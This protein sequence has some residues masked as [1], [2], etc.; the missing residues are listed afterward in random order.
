VNDINY[1]EETN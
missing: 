1:I